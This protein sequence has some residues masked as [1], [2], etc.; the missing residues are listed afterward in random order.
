ML[1][2][3]LLSMIEEAGTAVL[4]LTAT[5]DESQ[6]IG[7]KLTRREVLRQVKA[8]ADNAGRLPAET[9]KRLPDLDWEGWTFLAKRLEGDGREADE[10]LWFA[11]HSLV[12]ATLVG[13]RLYRKTQPE[14]FSWIPSNLHD[15]TC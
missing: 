11:V 1:N 6:L 2:A 14:L 3:L 8:M 10:A 9:R 15:T 12:P 13:L 7:S 4:T 5:L